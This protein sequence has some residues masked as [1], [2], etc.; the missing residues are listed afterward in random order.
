M[1]KKI[2]QIELTLDEI[3]I[4]IDMT[5]SKNPNYT[6]KEIAK[7]IGRSCDTIWKYQKYFNLK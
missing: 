4:I 6:R 5:K 3:K 1:S 2:G 7:A